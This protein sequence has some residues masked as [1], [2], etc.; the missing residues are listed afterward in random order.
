[1][2]AGKRAL[3]GPSTEA[4]VPLHGAGADAG[5]AELV[6][7]I[8]VDF[9]SQVLQQLRVYGELEDAIVFHE[10]GRTPCGAALL[11]AAA[12]WI[13]GDDGERI[14]EYHTAEEDGEVTG[15][16]EAAPGRPPGGV[17]ALPEVGR[18]WDL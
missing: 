11:E 16:E 18:G 5:E 8:L 6:R 10:S 4:T 17:E 13:E 9:G 15:L 12:A 7:V 3:I 1:M 2:T 14:G